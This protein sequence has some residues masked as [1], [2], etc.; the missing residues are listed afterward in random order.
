MGGFF[1]VKKAEEP[2]TVQ[3]LF[4]AILCADSVDSVGGGERWPTIRRKSMLLFFF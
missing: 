3:D 1:P 2:V 4:A